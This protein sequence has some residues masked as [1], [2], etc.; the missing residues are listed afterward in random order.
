MI[1]SKRARLIAA[2]IA[3]AYI[4]IQSFQ[5]YVFSVL[6][7]TNSPTDEFL[8]GSLSIN[9]WR[10]TLLLLSFWGLMYVF[11]VVCVQNLKRNFTAAVF[12]FLGFFIFC[13]LE[14]CLRS[15]ELFYFQI[16]LSAVY[17]QIVNAAEQKAITDLVANFQSVQL[18]LYFPL[19]LS[20]TIGSV[21][22]AVT[23][24]RSLRLNYLIVFAFALNGLR[25]VARIFGMFLHINWFDSFSND[26]YLPF[27]FVIFGLIGIWLLLIKSE[28]SL[29][30]AEGLTN[31]D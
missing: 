7:P 24:E 3:F 16:H 31:R 25:L 4:L 20:Q 30:L 29:N 12:A 22:L 1:T 28:V 5:S 17:Q 10:A 27:V 19:M 13:L 11:L 2:I 26:L 9:L 15:V 18:A 8:Q 23:F 21:V 6:P 14:V